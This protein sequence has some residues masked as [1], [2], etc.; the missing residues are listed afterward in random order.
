MKKIV[1][2]LIR[3]EEGIALPIILILMVV[4]GLI[5]APRSSIDEAKPENIKRMV[6]FTK[7]YGRYR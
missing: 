4:G 3:N 5:I 1:N 7:K 6:D 2:K